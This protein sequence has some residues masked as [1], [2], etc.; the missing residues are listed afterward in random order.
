MDLS[1][2]NLNDE[3]VKILS[4][5]LPEN[6][7]ELILDGCEVG[8]EGCK[9]L[10][11]NISRNSDISYLSLAG[12]LITSEGAKFIASILTDSQCPLRKLNLSRN[13]IE[14]HGV[15]TLKQAP[16]NCAIVGFTDWS[17]AVSRELDMLREE[18]RRITKRQ[19][20]MREMMMR[21]QH[22]NLQ[23]AWV[24][25][26]LKCK[27]MR[28]EERNASSTRVRNNLRRAL[29]RMFRVKL[30]SGFRTW[31]R[32]VTKQRTEETRRQVKRAKMRRFIKHMQRRVLSSAWRRFTHVI[33]EAR[34][35]KMRQDEANKVRRECSTTILHRVYRRIVFG[36]T[37]SAFDMWKRYVWYVFSR[38]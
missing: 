15:D 2:N 5:T 30:S 16:S 13:I 21:F 8:D 10:L 24:S 37:R 12:N 20:R 34:H 27:H 26:K 25:W 28:E 31:F 6:L 1:Y 23:K 14:R 32:N 18:K 36:I 7:K 38:T 19:R 3:G 17:D 11:S 22:Q 33:S 9:A 29:L 4:L 35:A